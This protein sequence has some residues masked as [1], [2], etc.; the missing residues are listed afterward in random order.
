MFRN[1]GADVTARLAGVHLT[2]GAWRLV[3]TRFFS[4]ELCVTRHSQSQ[5]LSFIRGT[6]KVKTCYSYAEHS[7]SK[8]II[9]TWNIQSQNLLF[10]RGT[11]RVKTYYSYATQSESKPII[12]TRHSQSQNLLFIRGTVRVKTYYS[13]AAQSE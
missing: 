5:N 12:H 4:L 6:L 1:P 8:P 9:H 2:T 13:Y 3:N 11:V 7:K 10:I